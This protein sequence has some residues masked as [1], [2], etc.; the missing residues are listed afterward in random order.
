MN[1][2]LIIFA[3]QRFYEVL[4]EMVLIK[5]RKKPVVIKAIQWDGTN[6]VWDKLL[7][8][9]LKDWNP[10]ETGTD[11]FFLKTLSG[12]VKISS[13]DWVIKGINGE[14]YPCK[15][16]IFHKTYEKVDD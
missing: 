7:K 10:G 3:K 9:G 14:F 15:P 6:K 16:D 4:R 11:T 1:K 13:G 8:I 5:Y 2:L 12:F